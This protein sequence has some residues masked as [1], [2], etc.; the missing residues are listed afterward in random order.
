MR[1]RLQEV[2]AAVAADGDSDGGDSLLLRV[3][4]D[5]Q[6]LGLSGEDEAAFLSLQLIIGAADTSQIST[7]SFLE[8]MLLFPNVQAEAQSEVDRL[9]G[10]R[11]PTWDDFQASR[12]FRALMKE[13]W[14][15]RPPVAL[16]H[17][18]VSTQEIV[19]E[20]MRIPKGARIHLNAWA[21][22]HDPA[23][24]PDPERFWPQRYMDDS[25]TTAQ[26]IN[27]ADAT[28]RDHFAFGAGRRVCPGVH[29]A[30]RSLGIAIMRI[31]WGFD[32]RLS[33]EATRPLHPPDYHSYM[34]GNAG[35]RMPV[36]MSVRSEEKRRLIDEAWAC[37]RGMGR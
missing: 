10:D 36:T 25:L 27:L 19:Y 1:N 34:P 3:L 32:I 35:P 15:F 9:V 7:W 29:V 20:G 28:Q 11:I 37:E 12:Y 23:R 33:P 31:L 26:S 6:L 4:R 8:A 17:P 5:D 16:G 14:R 30:E 21:I 13:V 24:H 22:Q 2:Q 18:H